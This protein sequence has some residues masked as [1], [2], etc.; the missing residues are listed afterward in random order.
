MKLD[1]EGDKKTQDL[2]RTQRV[3]L[4][5]KTQENKTMKI[6]FESSELE[7]VQTI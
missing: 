5:I 3:L 2:K 6:S 1:N 7:L 4:F